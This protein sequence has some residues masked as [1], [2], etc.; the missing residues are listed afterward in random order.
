MKRTSK[1]TS[2]SR[3]SSPRSRIPASKPGS[4]PTAA[5]QVLADLAA[6]AAHR[7]LRW[8]L[9][10]AQAVALYGVQR[11]SADVDVTV[12]LG[13]IT[14]RQIAADLRSAGMAAR[15]K[16]AGFIKATRVIPV[17]HAETGWPVDVVLAGPGV[18]EI[19]LDAARPMRVGAIEVPVISPEHL[20]VTKILAGRPVDLEDVRGLLRV[21]GLRLDLA[22]ADEILAL[23]EAALDQSDLRPCL[24]QLVAEVRGGSKRP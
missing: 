19:F 24:R 6:V 23:L 12:E 20:V 15:I 18:E 21:P 5:A 14:A 16:D 13:E 10:G 11:T 1:T 17:V 8:Y 7:D 4:I 3:R 9:F 2:G 22:V